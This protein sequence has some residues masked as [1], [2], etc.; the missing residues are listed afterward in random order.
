[1][2]LPYTVVSLIG[3]TSIKG[4]TAQFGSSSSSS[5]DSDANSG[6]NATVHPEVAFL[7]TLQA[8]QISSM[9]CLITLVNMTHEE[10]GTC[11]DIPTLSELVVKPNDTSNFA[12]QLDGYLSG[13]CQ[14][15]CSDVAIKEAKGQ[16]GSMCESSMGTSLVKVLNSILDSYT[17][18]YKTLACKVFLWVSSSLT[19]HVIP[20]AG[21]K[22]IQV[23][24]HQ[25]LVYRLR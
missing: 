14:S 15:E 10:I 6:K 25:K 12:T 23:M 3:I 21:Q 17:N 11:L 24:V 16:L 13:V 22:L 19:P 8:A 18:S 4:V 7:Q 2:W 20:L 1:M 5:S 9:S